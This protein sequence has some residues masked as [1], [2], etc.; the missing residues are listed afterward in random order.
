MV[1]RRPALLQRP[2][3]FVYSWGDSVAEPD[4]KQRMPLERLTTEALNPASSEFDRLSS[5]EIVEL[6]N[7]E[8]GRVAAAVAEVTPQIAS[9]ID[10]I[11]ERLA[12]G[13]RLVYLGAGT[14][15]RLGVLD[16]SECPPTFN[17]P[18]W[19]VVG[20]IAGGPKALTR[21]IEG[22]EDH[23]ELAVE[24]L[25]R[26]GLS[27][28][29]VLVGIAT[30]GRTPY[31]LGG[32]AWMKQLG[33]PTIGLACNAGSE[34]E[35]VADLVI[36]PV[37]GPEVLSG[38]TR[39][40]AGTATKLVLN[41]LSTGAMIR[42]GKS[43]GNLMVDLQ[44]TNSKLAERSRRIVSAA[45]GL[46]LEDAG[47]RL[48]ES[49]G[50]VKT[51]IVMH[52]SSVDAAEARRRL[53]ASGGRLREALERPTGVSGAVKEGTSVELILG[54]D[55]GG[56]K[57]RVWLC[58]AAEIVQNGP[59][60]LPIGTG[61][62]GPSN[63]MAVG[64]A[65]ATGNIDR[66]IELAFRSAGLARQTVVAITLA[67]AGLGREPEQQR[68]RTWAEQK[69]L[70][71]HVRVTHDAAVLL[72]AGTPEGTGIAL[73]AGTGSMAYGALADGTAARAGGWGALLGDEGSGYAI[74]VEGLKACAR[75]GDGR[76]AP[77]QMFDRFLEAVNVGTQADLLRVF[78]DRAEDRRWIAGLAQVVFDAASEGDDVADSIL[79]LAASDLSLLV[80]AVARQLGW[81]NRAFPLALAGGALV[82]T[83][84]LRERLLEILRVSG[85]NP[86]PVTLVPHP[87]V[88]AVLLAARSQSAP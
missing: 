76:G 54:V 41:M 19:Q 33:G 62:A 27:Q 50:D 5:R 36:A 45:T 61:E 23:P 58:R 31:V 52:R 14:S 86:D 83:P 88:G 56:S 8:D 1:C 24:D 39:L 81:G 84:R 87:V 70:A 49:R 25:R 46:S 34:L 22:A 72:A 6:M 37:V 68:M 7:A 85:S 40:K 30:S 79:T 75:A 2:D 29:D 10:R 28:A 63:P 12:A 60:V 69:L 53:S 20:V 59:R 82:E 57:T 26:I 44:A 48:D 51:A 64:W 15:G 47:R 74:A 67:H 16:A 11:A 18:P 66:A 73:V 71:R 55:G 43:F 80:E 13:G 32:L 77:T 38:S 42:L 9:A 4:L 65:A 3:R 17:S 35:S 78:Y 21:A